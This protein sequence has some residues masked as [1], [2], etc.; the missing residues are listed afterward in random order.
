MKFVK[1]GYKSKE[2]NPYKIFKS[3]R[4]MRREASLRG[5]SFGKQ[6]NFGGK[7]GR[8]NGGP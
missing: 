7:Y 2:H 4:Q 3:D 6:F 1:T 8:Y 5:I